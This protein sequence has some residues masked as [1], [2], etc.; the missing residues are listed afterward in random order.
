MGIVAKVKIL[1]RDS[2]LSNMMTH[3]ENT[4]NE[5]TSGQGDT[6]LFSPLYVII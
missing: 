1:Y 5:F 6:L 2:P 4:E 3:E